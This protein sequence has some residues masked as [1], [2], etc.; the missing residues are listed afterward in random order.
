MKFLQLTQ[1]EIAY[2]LAHTLWNVQDIP[3]LSSDAIRLAD[4]LSQ[5]IANDV[6]EYYTYGMRLPNYVNRLIKMTK[7][8]DASKEIAKDIQEISVMSKIFDIFHIE[9]SGCL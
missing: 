4:D 1:Y 5:Q 6:H 3:G 7:L 8:I 9:S 2:L